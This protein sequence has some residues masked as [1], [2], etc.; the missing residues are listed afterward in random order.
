MN[1]KFKTA[2]VAVLVAAV[3][4]GAYQNQVKDKTM[5]DL[6]LANAEAL[7]SF[8][9]N[10]PGGGSSLS[11]TCWSEQKR[12]SGYWKCGNPCS[13]IDGAGGKGPEGRCYKSN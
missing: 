7:A 11:W 6:I 4:Y 13:W 9:N 3:G 1:N 2:I 10:E 5:S 8:E 12:G